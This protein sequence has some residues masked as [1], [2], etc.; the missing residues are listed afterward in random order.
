MKKSKKNILLLVSFVALF[1]AGCNDNSVST[2][3]SVSSYEKE[4][5]TR[6]YSGGIYVFVNGEVEKPGVYL[7]DDDARLYQVIDKAGGMTEK[8]KKDY[9]NLAETVHDG[10]EIKVLSKKQYKKQKRATIREETKDTGAGAEDL[11]SGRVNINTADV[12][13]FTVLPGIGNTKAAAII[14]YREENGNFSS[15]EDIKNVSGIGEAT[16]NNI[17]SMITVD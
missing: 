7:V 15:I 17:E 4:N 16:F 8:A 12:E 9:L 11:G 1:L 14:A 10:Q 13:Q 2:D 6:G 5:D 3:L